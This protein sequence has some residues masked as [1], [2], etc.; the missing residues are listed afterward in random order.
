MSAE[1]F[2]TLRRIVVGV[3]D[4]PGRSRAIDKTQVAAPRRP[5][6]AGGLE[7]FLT[8]ADELGALSKTAQAGKANAK[9]LE[10][11]YVKTVAP[12]ANAAAKNPYNPDYEFAELIAQKIGADAAKLK[13]AKAEDAAPLLQK[14]VESTDA[15]CQT[16]TC[17]NVLI[18][19]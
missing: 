2:T 15:Y 14:L 12:L 4:A 19:R 16:L 11:G 5:A 7:Q 8:L 3:G 9:A 10:Q 13:V 6:N 1:F 18:Y 17:A